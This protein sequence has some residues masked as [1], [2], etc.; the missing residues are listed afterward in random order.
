MKE[1]PILYSTPMVLAKLE[2]RKTM[3]RRVVTRHNSTTTGNWSELVLE[4]AYVDHFGPLNYLKAPQPIDGTRHRICPRWEIG[5]LLWGRESFRVDKYFNGLMEEGHITY[6]AGCLPALERFGKWKP[7]IHMPK[8]AARI[9]EEITNIKVERLQD[10]TVEDCI[11]EGIK[12]DDDSGYFFAGDV[13]M[14]G[15]PINCYE[16]LWKSINGPDSWNI[17]PW[18]WVVQTKVLSINGRPS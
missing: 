13:A 7:S 10:I 6:K 9:W 8:I 17:N 5:D 15:D 16:N 12:F 18:V 2:G 4:D 11:A 3:T 1:H 14:A